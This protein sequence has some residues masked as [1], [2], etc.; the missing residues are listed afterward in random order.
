LDVA[1]EKLLLREASGAIR[2]RSFGEFEQKFHNQASALHTS[3]L[4]VSDIF[5]DFHPKTRPVL[6]RMLIAQ[7]HIYQAVLQIGRSGSGG[8]GI[9]VQ[10][11]PRDKRKSFDWRQMNAA[12]PTE[13]VLEEPFSVAEKYL[14][15]RL[16][17]QFAG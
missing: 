17:R 7:A 9:S 15:I 16:P 12:D 11:I 3:F 5:L 1:A 6:W 8:A 4:L 10:P 2:L 13:K 14:T